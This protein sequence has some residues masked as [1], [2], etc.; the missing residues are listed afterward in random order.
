MAGGNLS[1]PVSVRARFE[2]LPASIEVLALEGDRVKQ[3]TALADV[4]ALFPR[5]GL[6]AEL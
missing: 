2:R 5:F 3:I 1:D 6:P 4:D